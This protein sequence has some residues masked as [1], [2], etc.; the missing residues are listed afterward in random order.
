[1]YLTVKETAEYLEVSEMYVKNLI[2]QRK[3]RAVH[4]GDQFLINKAQFNTHMDQ[5]EKYKELIE[6]ILNEPIPEDI[7]VKDED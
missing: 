1:M 7:D 6:Q 4:D 3:I 5:L 2:N